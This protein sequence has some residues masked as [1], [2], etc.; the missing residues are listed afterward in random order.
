MVVLVDWLL[1]LISSAG[2]LS[3]LIDFPSFICLMAISISLINGGGSGSYSVSCFWSFILGELSLNRLPPYWFHLFRIF[4][5]F[6]Q[7]VSFIAIDAHLTGFKSRCFDFLSGITLDFCMLY[8]FNFLHSFSN[9]SLLSIL[10]LH[11][12][13]LFSSWYSSFLFDFLAALFLSAN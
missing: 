8:S 7:C 13:S 1:C 5:G 3:S 9:H 10:I 4:F 11:W 2:M 12:I 6:C